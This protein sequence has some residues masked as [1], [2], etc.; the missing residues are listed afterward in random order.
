MI[1]A[2]NHGS[3]VCLPV[4]HPISINVHCGNLQNS[5]CPMTIKKTN[6]VHP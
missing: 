4:N 2:L 5:I 3:Y 1:H 6:P